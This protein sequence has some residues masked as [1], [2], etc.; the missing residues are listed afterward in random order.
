MLNILWSRGPS[1]VRQVL[2]DLPA[3]TG[4]TTAL[5]QLQ[6]MSEKGL[7]TRDDKERSHVYAATRPAEATR[8]QLLDDLMERAF[9]GSAQQLVLQALS[10]KKPTRTELGELRRIIDSLDKKRP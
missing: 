8:G 1:T 10:G 5:K 9:G 4:Y 6:I 7:V 3:G 2:G